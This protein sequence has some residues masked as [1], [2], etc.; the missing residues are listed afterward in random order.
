MRL[1]FANI[2]SLVVFL[3]SPPILADEAPLYLHDLPIMPDLKVSQAESMVFDTPA[4]R[5][6]EFY[7]VGDSVPSKVLDFYQETLPQLGWHSHGERVFVRDAERL[8][9]QT[10]T[11]DHHLTV[12]FMLSPL[13]ES[14]E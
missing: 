9:I 6:V 12:H 8:E 14:K 13:S 5:I 1:F 7:A 2:L 3:V 4:G 10:V 11:K